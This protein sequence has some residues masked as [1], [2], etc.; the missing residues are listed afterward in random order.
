MSE[1]RPRRTRRQRTRWE[2]QDDAYAQ[3]LPRSGTVAARVLE[4][5]R[6]MPQTCDELEANLDLR[7]QTCSASVN[8][9]MRIGVIKAIAKRPTRSGYPANVWAVVQADG[10]ADT[11]MP[12][13]LF[14]MPPLRYRT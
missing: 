12:E 6:G 9:L 7:H 13:T 4:S 11:Q 3:S 2:T 8:S 1:I 10:S 5:L 14:P